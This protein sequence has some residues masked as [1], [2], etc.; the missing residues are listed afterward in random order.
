[1]GVSE[2]KR[3]H[4]FS[5]TDLKLVQ[6][7]GLDSVTNFESVEAKIS[8]LNMR[9]LY[10]LK[11]MFLRFSSEE[12][13]FPAAIQTGIQNNEL[14]AFSEAFFLLLK[15]QGLADIASTTKDKA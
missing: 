8:L 9:Q 14:R 11:L 6:E 3:S 13:C 4:K 12:T 10:K 7:L 2:E 1:L 5:E 15:A